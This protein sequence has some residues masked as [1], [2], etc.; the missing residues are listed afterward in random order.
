MGES[1]HELPAY[2]RSFFDIT[3]AVDEPGIQSQSLPPVLVLCC[4]LPFSTD[5]LMAKTA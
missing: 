1:G 4:M 3:E 5:T 2:C